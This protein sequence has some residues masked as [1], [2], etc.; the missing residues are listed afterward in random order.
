ML[1]EHVQ[2]LVVKRGDHLGVGRFA[3]GLADGDAPGF[4]LAGLQLVAEGADS[5]PQRLRFFHYLHGGVVAVEA[6][7]TYLR[8]VDVEGALSRD[9]AAVH[10]QAALLVSVERQPLLAQELATA[11]HFE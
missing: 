1:P 9:G 6:V 10:R 5:E 7:V 8:G 3:I 2:A 4:L 11:L